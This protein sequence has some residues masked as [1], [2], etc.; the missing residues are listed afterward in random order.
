MT[1]HGITGDHPRAYGP[2]EAFAAAVPEAGAIEW[3]RRP[4]GGIDARSIAELARSYDLVVL[5]H[6]GV[7]AAVAAG[8][9]LPIDTITS[10]TETAGWKDGSIGPTWDSYAWDDR[11]W[12]VPID[13]GTQVSVLRP[14]LVPAPPTDWDQVGALAAE[15]RVALCLG[16]PHALLTVLGMCAP[17]GPVPSAADLADALRLLRDLWSQVDQ[18]VS[19]LDPAG[20]HQAMATEPDLAYCPLAFGYATYARP[21]AGAVPLGWAAAPGRHGSGPGS[22]LGGTGLAVSSLCSDREGIRRWIRGYLAADVQRDVVAAAG[23]QPVA[24]AVWDAP[25][26]D[27]AWGGFYS[28]ARSSIEAAWVRPRRSGWLALQDAGSALVRAAVTGERDVDAA[29]KEIAG[30]VAA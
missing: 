3:D 11:Q 29:A 5:D 22:V 20:V 6:P 19:L 7:G 1:L 12:A 17:A 4:T 25:E 8:A 13:A 26:V 23:G 27:A 28:A 18:D 10:P 2:L 14:D 30:E 24:R 9:L 16:G 21:A 15:R